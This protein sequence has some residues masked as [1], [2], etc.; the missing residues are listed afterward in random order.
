MDDTKRVKLNLLPVRHTLTSDATSQ[1]ITIEG[2]TVTSIKR[3]ISSS[4]ECDQLAL[5]LGIPIPEMTFGN[6]AVS[7]KGPKG[8]KCEFTTR[9]ALDAV[10]KT[11]S[12]GITV[13]YSE[14]WNRTRLASW[15][16]LKFRARNS[17]DING[18]AKPYDWTYTTPYRGSIH[19]DVFRVEVITN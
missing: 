13:S 7:I 14:Q 15:R 6:N 4:A 18:I 3:P 17:E 8:W 11:G 1:S 10:D 9:E 2:W 12:Q 19:D 16:M 5:D